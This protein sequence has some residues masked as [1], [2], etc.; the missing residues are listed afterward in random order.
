MPNPKP[1][2]F[3][4]EDLKKAAALKKAGFKTSVHAS[5]HKD[6]IDEWLAK[7]HWSPQKVLN[8]LGRMYPKEEFMSLKAMA[9]YRDNYLF[10]EGGRGEVIAE[11]PAMKKRLEEIW[12]DV[13]APGN[14]KKILKA[15]MGRFEEVRIK[16]LEF[17]KST[18]IPVGTTSEFYEHLFELNENFVRVMQDLGGVEKVPSKS[19]VT[20]KDEL[21]D[22]STR[23]E[24]E[25]YV[26]REAGQLSGLIGE[27]EEELR[28]RGTKQKPKPDDK[29]GSAVR[30]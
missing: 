29:S 27:I 7:Y 14:M 20:V 30:E 13:N 10:A 5:P 8:E 3:T 21:T 16:S 24:L 9:N 4:P 18:G 11:Y 19:E 15:A 28:L 1:R 6:E 26:A 12:N 17:E 25:Q 23:E 22:I 2:E